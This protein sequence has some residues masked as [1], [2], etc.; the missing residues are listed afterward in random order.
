MTYED[1]KY[2]LLS[3]TYITYYLAL[4]ILLIAMKFSQTHQTLLHV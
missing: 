1:D 3:H 4:F 2:L